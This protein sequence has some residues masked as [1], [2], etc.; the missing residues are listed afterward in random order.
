MKMKKKLMNRKPRDGPLVLPV[1]GC[2]IPRIGI[3]SEKVWLFRIDPKSQR[4][5]RRIWFFIVK[6]ANRITKV[7]G[8]PNLTI[9]GMI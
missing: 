3:D 4:Q 1:W 7:R 5:C 2:V 8:G 6:Y 9:F